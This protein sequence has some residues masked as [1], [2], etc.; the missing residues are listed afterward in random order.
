MTLQLMLIVVLQI[1]F[2]VRIGGVG[3]VEVVRWRLVGW[4]RM[5]KEG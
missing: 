1:A 4:R 2:F 5:R 3:V